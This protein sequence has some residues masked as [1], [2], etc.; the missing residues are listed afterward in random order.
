MACVV[1]APRL[2]ELRGG[3]PAQALLPALLGDRATSSCRRRSPPTLLG[4][5]AL[6]PHGRPCAR[7]P[8]SLNAGHN[9]RKPVGNAQQP[10]ARRGFAQVAVGGLPSQAPPPPPVPHSW[11]PS[12]SAFQPHH[13]PVFNFSVPHVPLSKSFCCYL[14]T[15]PATDSRFLTGN[16]WDQSV[17]ELNVS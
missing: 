7:D 2:P 14:P 16:P 8:G 13:S 11:S 6:P 15:E 12:V 5:P 17:S 4:L 3:P 10:P 1:S 9:G